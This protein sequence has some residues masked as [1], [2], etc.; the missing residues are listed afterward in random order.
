MNAEGKTDFNLAISNL[1]KLHEEEQMMNSC[2][3]NKRR[4]K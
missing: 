2:N 3:I 4:I 1:Q